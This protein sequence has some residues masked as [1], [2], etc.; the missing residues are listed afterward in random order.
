MFVDLFYEVEHPSNS[1]C[2]P[3]QID[4]RVF[5]GLLLVLEMADNLRF[6]VAVP[7]VPYVTQ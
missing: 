1:R 3:K 2:D 5:V 6:L 7:D 4:P